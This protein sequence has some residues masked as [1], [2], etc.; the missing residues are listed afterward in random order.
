MSRLYFSRCA[1]ASATAGRSSGCSAVDRAARRPPPRR[2]RRPPRASCPCARAGWPRRMRPTSSPGSIAQRMS[3][4]RSPPPA[5]RS[6]CGRR[7][8]DGPIA[9]RS[10]PS[11]STMRWKAARAAGMSPCA[12]RA[13]AE[14]VQRAQW[15]GSSSRIRFQCLTR[16]G[17]ASRLRGLKRLRFERVDFG[18]LLLN[19]LA[20]RPSSER[21]RSTTRASARCTRR[22][23][24]TSRVTSPR[25]SSRQLRTPDLEQQDDA[26]PVAAV[27]G[28]VLDRVVEHPCLAF[29]RRARVVADAKAAL[30]RDDQRQVADQAGVDEARVRRN[31]SA[32]AQQ[33]EQDRRRAV[34]DPESGT[35]R[36]DAA[37]SAGSARRSRARSR[38]PST[39]R[40]RSSP[41]CPVIPACSLRG[42]R[43]SP[44]T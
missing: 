36:H 27:P 8:R 32:G 30:R 28:F 33:R 23:L 17:L 15:F 24:R 2:R 22:S 4:S 16:L 11:T 7:R 20:W 39:G 38:R 41:D 35:S 6:G 12:K 13:L 31:A 26:R 10:D 34:R 14:R 29:D 9:A 1:C 18:D 37:S 19:G 3:G 25:S 21:L 44:S 43:G 42:R 40:T 5:R